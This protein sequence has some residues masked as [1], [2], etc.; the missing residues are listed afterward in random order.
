LIT[1]QL[2]MQKLFKQGYVAR[3]VVITIWL[4]VM[5]Y[6]YLK[7]QWIFYFL[8]KKF[9]P[10]SL[11]RLVPK[12]HHNMCWTPL[13]ANKHKIIRNSERKDIIGQHK[14]LKR[15]ATRTPPKNRKWTQMLAKFEQFL[16]LI[17]H[18]PC[19][20]YTPRSLIIARFSESNKS[21]AQI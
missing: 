11:P 12:T 19:Y 8:Q 5:K 2:L 13:C 10:L 14:K 9:F 1:A 7:W 15:W 17:R 21:T 4:T 6:S 20:L 16:L 18:P 3:T